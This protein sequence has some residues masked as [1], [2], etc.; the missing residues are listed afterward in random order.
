M[1]VAE[2]AESGEDD[3]HVKGVMTDGLPRPQARI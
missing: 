2:R 1:Q 3:F